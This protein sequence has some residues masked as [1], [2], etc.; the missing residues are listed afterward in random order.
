M[1]AIKIH[2]V[3]DGT[4]LSVA[5]RLPAMPGDE[6]QAA[7]RLIEACPM[8]E[9][10]TLDCT[11]GCLVLLHIEDTGDLRGDIASTCDRAVRAWLGR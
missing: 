10:L 7:V 1:S 2:E 5:L 9:R 11:V 4:P 6:A 8:V 3:F